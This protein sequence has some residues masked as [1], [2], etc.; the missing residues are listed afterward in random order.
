MDEDIFSE[1]PEE[2]ELDEAVLPFEES[3]L[4]EAAMAGMA[5]AWLAEEEEQAE[6]A[7]SS[8]ADVVEEEVEAPDF[9]DLEEEAAAVE[10]VEGLQEEPQME[11]D[12]EVEELVK[13][14]DPIEIKM[15]K[16]LEYV[17]GI[18]PVYAAKLGEI[19]ILTTGKLMVEGVTRTG[20]QELAEKTDISERLILK[21][22]NMIDLYRIK[23]IGSE[24]GELL[25]AAGVD[26][27]PELAQRNADNL[28]QALANTNE[29]KRLVRQLPTPEQVVEWVEQ[30]KTMP[31]IIQY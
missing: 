3:P 1:L 15:R 14:H 28:Y 11:G 7:D 26:T 17:E 2:V 6:A 20:R 24:Y 19:G 23:G 5:A 10:S 25:E 27:V 9:T 31:R 12:P 30:A 8:L 13:P 18:G 29:E 16:K 21:W 4:E 22:L